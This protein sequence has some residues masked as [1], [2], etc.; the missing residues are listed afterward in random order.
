MNFRVS[1][2]ADVPAAEG[3]ISKNEDVEQRRT[4][5]G[6]RSGARYERR[7][8]RELREWSDRPLARAIR[9]RS[10]SRDH[11]ESYSSGL[12]R[13]AGARQIAESNALGL[14][15]GLLSSRADIRRCKRQ[16]RF[17][18]KP[19]RLHSIT[20]S[21][22]ATSN[23]GSSIPS[24]FAVVRLMLN[25]NWVGW[26]MGIS[27]GFSPLSILSAKSATRCPRSATSIP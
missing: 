5:N 25:S 17:G 7:R 14:R 19:S 22:R 1:L 4:R 26:K 21:A 24:A 9:Q 2:T 27:P 12:H 11:E 23:G 18:Q 8:C 10:G 20:L 13:R 15:Q 3:H 16:F 6:A